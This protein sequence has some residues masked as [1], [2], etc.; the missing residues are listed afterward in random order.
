MYRG[1]YSID[2]CDC[3][4]AGWNKTLSARWRYYL[5]AF[6]VIC[7]RRLWSLLFCCAWGCRSRMVFQNTGVSVLLLS[8]ENMTIGWIKDSDMCRLAISEI[9][10]KIDTFRWAMWKVCKNW[11]AQIPDLRNT[12]KNWYL[13]IGGFEISGSENCRREN[14]HA[15]QN[16]IK[17]R[18][19][20]RHVKQKSG[21]HMK[22]HHYCIFVYTW[23]IIIIIVYYARSST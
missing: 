14:L 8:I 17:P 3:V 10:I 7:G 2:D 13:E 15:V 16:E 12:R 23:L 1:T 18:L 22:K 20:W 19:F 11:Y 6:V 4:A 21:V 5:R 9:W